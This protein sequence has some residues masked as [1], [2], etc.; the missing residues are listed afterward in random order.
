[1]LPF[2]VVEFVFT[3]NI[4]FEEAHGAAHVGIF[5]MP[6]FAGQ[7]TDHGACTSPLSNMD[8]AGGLLQST[9]VTFTGVCVFCGN[10]IAFVVTG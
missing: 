7:C 3:V 10:L 9:W 6:T 4:G 5:D 1:M 8:T 2:E